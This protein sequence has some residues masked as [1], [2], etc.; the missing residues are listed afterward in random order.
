MADIENRNPM[1]T[2]TRFRIASMTKPVTAVAALILIEE[3]KL[4]LDDPIEQYLPLAEKIRVALPE[5]Q[6]INDTFATEPLNRPITI[7]DLLTFSSGAGH[8][9]LLTVK[10]NQGLQFVGKK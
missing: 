3:G 10:A 1:N 4:K 5:N 6:M 7:L 9:D 8:S 2:K